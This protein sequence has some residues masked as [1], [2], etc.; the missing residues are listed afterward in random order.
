[1]NTVDKQHRGDIMDEDDPYDLS[2]LFND[3]RAR[4]ES[5]AQELG[6]PFVDL[7]VYRP[8]AAALMLVPQE[9][10]RHHNVIPVRKD[11]NIIYVAMAD[12]SNEQAADEIRQVSRCQV[13][14]VLAVPTAIRAAIQRCYRAED[15]D[16][17]HR[18][19]L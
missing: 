8:D 15:I 16:R 10:A 7:T 11:G 19:I 1:M 9:M 12:V 4:Y 3:P 13:R 6:V 14:C 5:F 18:E 17:N 2:K